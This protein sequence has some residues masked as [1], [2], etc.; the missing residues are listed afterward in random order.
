MPSATF[1]QPSTSHQQ[2]SHQTPITSTTYHLALSIIT[3]S[4]RHAPSAITG[5]ASDSSRVQFC[6]H[7]LLRLLPG[8]KQCVFSAA[9]LRHDHWRVQRAAP[10]EA[11]Q[12]GHVKEFCFGCICACSGLDLRYTI[13]PMASWERSLVPSLW[14]FL[15]MR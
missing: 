4:D 7:S 13:V 8:P 6:K 14:F 2:I 10:C 5:S 1:S 15:Q 9:T 3:N 12:A 11:A